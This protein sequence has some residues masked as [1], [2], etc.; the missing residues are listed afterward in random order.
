M[1]IPHAIWLGWLLL[2]RIES[3]EPPGRIDGLMGVSL[4]YILWFGLFPL[5]RL[6]G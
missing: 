3:G 1:A 4:T 2:R 6:A 5:L